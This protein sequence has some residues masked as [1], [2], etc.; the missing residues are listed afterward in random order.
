[1]A[2]DLDL[3]QGTWSITSM[4]MDGQKAAAEMAGAGRIRIRGNR[5]TTT[6]MGAAYEG[7]L[8]LDGKARP[9]QIS[10]K[11][12]AGPEKGNTNLGIYELKGDTWKL[13]LATR[14]NVRP[15]K[16]ASKPGSG[17]AVEIL[18]RGEIAPAPAKATKPPSAANSSAPATELEGEWQMLSGVMDGK[19]MDES[20]VKWVKRV[21]QGNITTVLAGPQTMLKAE[22]TLDAAKS[23]KAI[24]Y[25]N[26]A[27]SHK[28][29]KQLGIYKIEQQVLTMNIA[30]PGA[31]RPSKF[32]PAKGGT[33]TVWKK[34]TV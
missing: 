9:R 19:P 21:T 16:F 6:G 18:Q 27:G 26:L 1:M 4:E 17:I 14:G 3:L 34:S 30:A 8:E 11:F 22:F 31:T 7:V 15:S 24:D 33:L 5:F 20:L 12:D 23:P 29:K 10:M 32:E 28:G 13:C 2:S 25:L